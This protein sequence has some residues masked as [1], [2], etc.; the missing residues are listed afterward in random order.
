MPQALASL[1]TAV[2]AKLKGKGPAK[3]HVKFHWGCEIDPPCQKNI[4]DTYGACCFDDVIALNVNRNSKYMYC[5]THFKPCPCTV[6]ESKDRFFSASAPLKLVLYYFN[7][8]NSIVL[9]S[10]NGPR[11]PRAS[12]RT[13]SD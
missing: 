2:A 8:F 3:N 13:D 10:I 11:N 5:M 12:C 1:E 6:P 4:A 7:P 9:Q